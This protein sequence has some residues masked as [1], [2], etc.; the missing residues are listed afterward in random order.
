MNIKQ[1]LITLLL[2]IGLIPT[3]ATGGIA[4]ITISREL[5]TNTANQLESISIK[6]EQKINGLLQAKQEQVVQLANKFDLQIALS[7]YL[8]MRDDNARER[9]EAALQA[10]K[11]EVTDMQVITVSD[12]DG[13]VFASTLSGEVGKS[14]ANEDY[15]QNRGT[16]TGVTVREDPRDGLNKLYITTPLSVNK[17][18]SA[19]MSVVFRID[20][21]TAAVQDYTGL[22][23]SGETVVAEK[24]KEGNAISLFPLRFDTDAALHTKLDSLDLFDRTDT[25]Y[26]NLHDYRGQQVITAPRSIGFAN[27][28]IATKIDTREAY[29]PIV[30]LRNSL[31]GIVLFSSVAITLIALYFSRFFT[32]PIV[33]I[34]QVS[35]RIGQGD[36][37]A[38]INLDRKDELGELGKSINA[39]GLSL[40]EFVSSIE[41]QRHRLEIILNSTAESIV[42][43][44][45]QGIVTIAN[46]AAAQLCNRAI[47]E[48][49]GKHI[50]DIFSW[51]HDGQPFTIDYAVAESA[52]YPDLQYIDPAGSTHFLRIVVA[53]ASDR[54][55]DTTAQTI[56]TIHDETKG[57]EL[58][59][60]K[61]DFVSMAAHEL[62][63]PLAAT[64]GYLELITYKEG[65]AIQPEVKGYLEQALKS[66]SE[67]SSLIN[68]LLNVARIERGTLTFNPERIDL[69]VDVAQA[70]TDAQ[71]TAKDKNVSLTYDG[72]KSGCIVI[73][74]KIAIHEVINNLL[75][76]AIKYTKQNG[77]VA[78]RLRRQGD[79]V[80][81][82]V[83]D[84][85]MGIP[86]QA[87]PNLFTKFYRVHGGLSS[88]S[89]GT[90]L[91][92]FIAKS[93]IERHNG[94]ISVQSEEGV[95]SIFTFTLP[96]MS[97]A[98]LSATGNTAEIPAQTETDAQTTRRNRGW[99]TKNIAR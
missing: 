47:P 7:E 57:R 44:D 91:G 78:V 73:A 62:R 90:G 81:V 67:L 28:V 95:G 80:M 83:K 82:E 43:I 12:L 42:A 27:W 20:D 18:E 4:Y 21:I 34:A 87:M 86:K 56:I 76:N 8:Q 5:K 92:L 96:L 53:Q 61:V 2:F 1:K 48:I 72:V 69:A 31:I 68:N 66:T 32:R 29:A 79:R 88:G 35:R 30:Q 58:E 55:A 84:T 41:S 25:V 37:G 26:S 39:M 49:V 15:F 70:V 51:K 54:E 93:I 60:M 99:S 74:D 94:T 59:N 98:A 46:D 75:S 6:Q 11:I 52:T 85:G 19:V 71:F 38:R 9:V 33:T 97:Q 89:T 17:Q 22:G 64:R 63:T 16:Q 65:Q 77:S 50:N 14:V 36:F 23:A 13:N 10:K 24:D 3:L 40:N 45:Q